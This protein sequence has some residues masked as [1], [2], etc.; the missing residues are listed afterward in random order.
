MV[1]VHEYVAKNTHGCIRQSKLE[2]MLCLD[3]YKKANYVCC[4]KQHCFGHEKHSNPAKLWE[5]KKRR[6]LA[7]LLQ[8]NWH[9]LLRLN[10]LCKIMNHSVAGAKL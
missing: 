2:I 1:W 9:F 7:F 5:R 6:R 3:A 8:P 10:Y 4:E